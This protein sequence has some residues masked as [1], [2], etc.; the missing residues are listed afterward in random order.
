MRFVIEMDDD[1][2][3][4]NALLV[5]LGCAV[6]DMPSF[7]FGQKTRVVYCQPN[8]YGV[9]AFFELMPPKRKAKHE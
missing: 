8:D 9:R 5:A 4:G 7:T 3:L 6:A 2:P 1:A